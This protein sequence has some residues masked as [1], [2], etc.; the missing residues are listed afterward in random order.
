[1]DCEIFINLYL[2]I[3]GNPRLMRK[4]SSGSSFDSGQHSMASPYISRGNKIIN[5]IFL[6]NLIL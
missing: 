1:M 3:G 6:N 4:Q 2:F 5:I